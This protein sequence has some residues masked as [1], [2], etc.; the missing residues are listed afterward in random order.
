MSDIKFNF[1]SW[2]HINK[3][4]SKYLKQREYTGYEITKQ[5]CQ[6]LYLQIDC[7]NESCIFPNGEDIIR[8]AWCTRAG[9]A[10]YSVR[11]KY[12]EAGYL[13]GCG[14]LI[15]AAY[16]FFK[17]FEDFTVD[18]MNDINDRMTKYEVENAG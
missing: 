14:D 8:F 13:R 17:F 7:Q 11:Y 2:E 16:K 3:E 18:N 9:F 6:D 10:I 15:L 5:L 4:N 1:P 12:C